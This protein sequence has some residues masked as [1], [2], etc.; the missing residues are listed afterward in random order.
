MGTI[1]ASLNINRFLFTELFF[2]GNKLFSKSLHRFNITI[3]ATFLLLG[4]EYFLK[5]CMKIGII[6]KHQKSFKLNTYFLILL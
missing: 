2:I 4:V 5:I 6:F 1:Y 3:K